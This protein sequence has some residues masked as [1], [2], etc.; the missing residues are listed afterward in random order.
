MPSGALLCLGSAVA[1]GAMAIFGKLAYGE[2]ATVMTLL[3]GRFALAA[4][5]FWVLVAATGAARHLRTISRRDVAMALALGGI[6]YSAQAGA[7]FAGLKRMDASLL[8]LLLYTFPAMVAIAAIALGRERA[9]RRKAAALALASIGLVLVL[10]G[11]GGA[12]DPLGAALGVVAAAIYSTYIL[13]SGGVAGRVDPIVLSAIV[14]TGAATT[15]TL[16]GVAG[17]DLRL[18]ELSPQGYGWLAAIAV[19]S[20]VIAVSLFFAGLRRVGPTTAS[21]LST[22]EPVTTVILAFLAFGEALSPVQL[23]GGALVLGAVIVLS[24]SGRLDARRARLAVAG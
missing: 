5:L 7:Y 1:F 4:V 12:L 13:T 19:V 11:A 8:S 15:L 2:G 23:G 24:A 16:A 17:G 3:A 21:I 20:T 22:A 10:A 6:G 18:G 9:S 14:C